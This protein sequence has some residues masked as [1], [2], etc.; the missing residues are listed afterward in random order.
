MTHLLN[1]WINENT[2]K[3]IAFKILDDNTKF[4]ATKAIKVIK[5]KRQ[6]ESFGKEIEIVEAG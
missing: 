3:D 2:I 6:S 4:T 5:S 1:G